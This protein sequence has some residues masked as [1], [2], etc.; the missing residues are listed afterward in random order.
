MDANEIYREARQ[1]FL[2]AKEKREQ[3]AAAQRQAAEIESLD[4]AAN[5]REYI[6]RRDALRSKVMQPDVPMDEMSMS[7]YLKVRNEQSR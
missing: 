1:K 7:D 2:E 5:M 3:A 4:S 6:E